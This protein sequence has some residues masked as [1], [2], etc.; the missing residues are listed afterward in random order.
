M[1]SPRFPRFLA[2]CTIACLCIAILNLKL[3]QYRFGGYDLSPLIDSGWRVYQGQV[4]NRDFICTFPPVL[5]LA[6]AL[7]FRLFGVRWLAITLTGAAFP[8][9]LSVAGLRI[10][11]LL[12][13]QIHERRL[14]WLALIYCVL[15]MAP[16]LA[17]GFPWHS[18]WTEA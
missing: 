2:L 16:L 4:P 9:F 12:R 5:Y 1:R 14:R 13:P 7:A 10:T 17:I 15:Q 8:L 11:H 6:I 3:L 18:S